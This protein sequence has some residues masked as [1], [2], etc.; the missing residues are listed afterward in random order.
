MGNIYKRKDVKYDAILQKKLFSA[1]GIGCFAGTVS[2]DTP[3][4]FSGRC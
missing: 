1:F 3:V 4:G 2:H